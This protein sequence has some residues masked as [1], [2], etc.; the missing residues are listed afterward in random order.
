MEWAGPWTFV[1]KSDREASQPVARRPR[2]LQMVRKPEARELP[3]RLR[4]KEISI[5]HALVTGGVAQD[6]P[7]RTIWLIMNFPLYWASA[8]GSGL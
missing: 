6:R 1:K 5:R 3:P 7:R 4:R 2:H 8:P